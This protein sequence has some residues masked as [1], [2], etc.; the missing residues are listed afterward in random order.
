MTS[1]SLRLFPTVCAALCLAAGAVA[2]EPAIIAKARTLLGSEA[3]LNAVTSVHYTGTLTTTDPT[4]PT[5]K[6][7]APID[8]I[9]QK[10]DQQRIQASGP[11]II[12][13]TALDG[14]DGWQRQQETA[15]PTKWQQT[16]LGP[17]QIKSLRANT[18]ENLSFF[19]PP[20]GAP[21]RVEET[22]TASFDGID[23]VKISYTHGP[24]IVFIRYFEKTTGG[25]V[26]T[27]TAAGGTIRE[28]GEIRVSGIKFP[29]SIVTTSK[30]AA[31]QLQRVTID[32][33][34]VVV[35]EPFPAKMFAPPALL[36]R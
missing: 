5:K 11:R 31:G 30:N 7:S 2:A 15:D 14:Y 1:F 26:F 4:D 16:L 10:P 13:V 29:K 3:A 27:E 8:I 17:D 23:C 33:D 21:V 6:T 25:L 19:R 9:F 18:I 36:A 12:E 34:K 24:K 20:P 22:G 32:F 35:N 28:S